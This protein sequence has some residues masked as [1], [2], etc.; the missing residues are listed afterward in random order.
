M[1]KK[2]QVFI[3]STY[4]DLKEE[5]QA[6]VEAVLSAGHIPAGM[7]LFS[8]GNE[9]QIKV[10]KRW[11]DES[12]VYL[13]I[14]GGRYGSIEPISGKSYIELEYEY[15][16]SLD[17]PLFAIIINENALDEKVKKQGKDV[18][19]RDNFPMYQEFKKC[20][21]GKMCKFYDDTKDIKLA[22]YSTL[23]D[24]Q[25]R[26]DLDGWVSG[27][28]FKDAKYYTD[29]VLSF[30]KENEAL[31]KENSLL[32]ENL[33]KLN[34]KIVVDKSN[35]V[36][37]ASERLDTRRRVERI[38]ELINSESVKSYDSVFGEASW[39]VGDD[40]DSVSYRT[41]KP[42]GA[43]RY[44][45]VYA[46]IEKEY[47]DYIISINI[48]ANNKINVD[49]ALA[50]IRVMLDVQKGISGIVRIKYVLASMII[51]DEIEEQCYKFFKN[52]LKICRPKN[53]DI[54]EF[55]IW[56]DNKLLEIEKKL[57]LVL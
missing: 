35:Q 7:E 10:I 55:E 3:S 40:E 2:Y 22:I 48:D 1:D 34:Q 47:V 5:R 28:D 57:G 23:Q 56:N 13:L 6:A 30:V 49:S 32:K 14:L 44:Y 18:L 54:F 46:D 20:V 21:M 31:K 25:I 11:I 29:E 33:T 17:K 24:F 19:E 38:L 16:S 51:K 26:Y 41:G 50:D 39:E 12:D 27:K 53:K 37:I 43:F 4:I 45:Y 15:A 9:E 42:Q 8:A 52:A 36:A